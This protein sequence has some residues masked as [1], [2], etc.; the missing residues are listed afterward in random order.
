MAAVDVTCNVSALAVLV[1]L[2]EEEEQ[3]KRK[4]GP[5]RSWLRRRGERGAF[6]SIVREPSAEDTASYRSFMRMDV[7]TFHW[8]AEIIA[9]SGQEAHSDENPNFS[10]A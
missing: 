2:W 6:A 9:P 1:T 7:A 8:L 10:T 5:D 3:E 4:K